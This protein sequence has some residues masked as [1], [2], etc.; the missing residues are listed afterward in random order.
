MPRERLSSS[1]CRPDVDRGVRVGRDSYLYFR[2]RPGR[3]FALAFASSWGFLVV[4]DD[5]DD[6][7]RGE[8][9]ILVTA[10]ILRAREV[11]KS[12][13]NLRD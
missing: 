1:I 11:N 8:S 6:V 10:D 5:I 7:C 12:C 2:R 9:D 3:G 4:Q 13:R